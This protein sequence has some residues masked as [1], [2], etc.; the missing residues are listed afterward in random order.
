MI[1]ANQSIICF[2]EKP[3][4]KLA[5]LFLVVVF[6]EKFKC[7]KE[8]SQSDLKEHKDPLLV[9]VKIPPGETSFL[10]PIINYSFFHSWIFVYSQAHCKHKYNINQY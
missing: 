3:E 6:E 10:F 7:F 4:Y 5:F 8:I 9:E 1:A 2:S